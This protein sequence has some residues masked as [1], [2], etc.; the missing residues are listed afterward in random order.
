MRIG[1][2]SSKVELKSTTTTRDAVG[3]VVYTTASKG[4]VWA[5]IEQLSAA[6]ATFADGIDQLNSYRVT[7]QFD[8]A[9]VPAKGWKVYWGSKVLEVQSAWTDLD[10]RDYSYMTCLEVAS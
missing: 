8:S 7:M 2:L 4:S 3:Q 9:I 10:A 1:A 5:H 6:D